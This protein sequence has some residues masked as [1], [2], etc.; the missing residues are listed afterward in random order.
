[1]SALNA[2]QAADITDGVRALLGRSV[3]V[4]PV[5]ARQIEVLVLG[6]VEPAI[7]HAHAAKLGESYPVVFKTLF[8]AIMQLTGEGATV[9]K[10]PKRSGVMKA[11]EPPPQ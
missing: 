9:E 6:S 11:S 8:N 4:E 3:D 7:T 10:K 2:G 5:Y 1:V